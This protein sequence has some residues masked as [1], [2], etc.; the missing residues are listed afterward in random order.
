MVSLIRMD[1]TV[2]EQHLGW[3]QEG[4]RTWD[5]KMETSCSC[6]YVPLMSRKEVWAGDTKWL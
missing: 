3:R 4:K 5:F 1:D 6:C 2:C